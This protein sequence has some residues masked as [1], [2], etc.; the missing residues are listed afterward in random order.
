[1]ERTKQDF[2]FWIEIHHFLVPPVSLSTLSP[3]PSPP[4]L[5]NYN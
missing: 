2:G 5:K 3:S 1:V 4:L